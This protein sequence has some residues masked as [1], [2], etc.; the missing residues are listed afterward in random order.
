MDKKFITPADAISLL[1]DGEDIHTFRNPNGI[2]IGCDIDRKK[3]IELL[4]NNP[5]K[6]EL[7]GEMCKKLNHGVILY[8]NKGYLF[9]E[10]DFEKLNAFDPI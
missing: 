7:G 2:L 1:K 5:D 6:I 4:N 10:T 3:I 8:D 9:I